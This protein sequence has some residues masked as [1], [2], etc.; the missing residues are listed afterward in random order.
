MKWMWRV[1]THPKAQQSTDAWQN[2]RALTER[3]SSAGSS[4]ARKGPGQSCDTA[5]AAILAEPIWDTARGAG[6]A[7][8][9]GWAPGHQSRML[10]HSHSHLPTEPEG[11]LRAETQ[12]EH[13]IRHPW[14]QNFYLCF[15]RTSPLPTSC[16]N[17]LAVSICP[18]I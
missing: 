4:R 18:C 13:C 16:P 10:C 6:R 11:V 14:V 12:Q 5:R 8:S 3:L 17:H 9:R 1:G 7:G 15:R 2:P